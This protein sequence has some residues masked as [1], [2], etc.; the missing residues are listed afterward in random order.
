MSG[1]GYGYRGYPTYNALAPPPDTWSKTSYAPDH[2]CKPVIVD[3]DGRKH[4]IVYN[5][6]YNTGTTV[7]KTETVVEQHVHSSFGPEYK[8]SSHTKVEPL[9]HHGHV[10]DMWH[11]PSSPV[12][13]HPH[14]VHSP[15]VTEYKHSSHTKVEP[16]NHHGHVEDNWHKPSSPV[17]DRPHKVDEFLTKVQTEVS[18]PKKFGPPS[19]Y[20]RQSPNSTGYHGH[21]TTGYGDYS[22][23]W[24]KP[25]G[26]TIRNGDHHG[27][28][29]NNGSQ[30]E[31]T[32]ITSGG[33]ARP[34]RSGW[35][36][37][38]DA[39]LSRPTNDIGAAVEFLKEVAKPSSVTTS[40][41]T[42]F[43]VPITT[44]QKKDGYGET[45]DSR[46][47]SKRYGNFP[48]SFQSEEPY[49]KTIDSREAARKY[50]GAAV[51]V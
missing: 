44:G 38:P 40:P 13:G 33:W 35:A 12:P 45:I 1:F 25:S 31:P 50:K 16:L 30:V 43:T 22:K 49:T 3:A 18:Q 11:K 48:P 46:E 20:W 4:P 8:H 28:Y 47:A 29:Q 41:H 39:S 6:G 17:H 15:F 2:V 5:P 51:P 23:D 7:T 27:H 32:L 36:V 21:G 19:P 9:N 34:S 42:R 14:K 24:H 10:E 26:N 37:P